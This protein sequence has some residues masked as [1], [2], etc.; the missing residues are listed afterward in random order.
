MV[1]DAHSDDEGDTRSG[2]GVAREGERRK[3]SGEKRE[4]Q[5]RTKNESGQE[6]QITELYLD[7]VV[8]I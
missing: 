7:D 5:R 2:A 4:E 8:E 3:L 6:S 1:Y